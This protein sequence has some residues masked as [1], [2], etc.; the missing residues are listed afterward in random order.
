MS[1][2][3][4]IKVF[5]DFLPEDLQDQIENLILD[6]NVKYQY[7]PYTLPPNFNQKFQEGSQL[8]NVFVNNMNFVDNTS[9]LTGDM[10]HFFL[11]PIQI[12]CLKLGIKFNFNQLLRAKINLKFKQQS[13]LDNFINPPHKDNDYLNSLIGIYYINNSDG[14]TIIYEGT[15]EK[16]LKPIK[17]IS[18]KKGRMILMDGNLYHSSSHPLKTEIRTV[19]NFNL[20][21]YGKV[22]VNK[23]I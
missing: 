8:V 13:K 17:N 11:L 12:A 7:S 18:P 6:G 5:D 20:T 15:E 4:S 10:S 1:K 21:K 16:F 14:D 3:Q 9:L 2:F 22:S 19:I 23:S